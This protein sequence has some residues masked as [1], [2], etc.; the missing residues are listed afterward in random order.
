[1]FASCIFASLFM[2]FMIGGFLQSRMEDVLIAAIVGFILYLATNFVRGNAFE[3]PVMSLVLMILWPVVA[4]LGLWGMAGAL[5]YADGNL[6]SFFTYA[7]DFLELHR[8]ETASVPNLLHRQFFFSGGIIFA[9]LFLA[10]QIATLLLL[11]V[12]TKPQKKEF[13]H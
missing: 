3:I 10:S 13:R 6:G 9:I 8:H 2:Y 12:G 4:I 7:S 11:F 5:S 1:M